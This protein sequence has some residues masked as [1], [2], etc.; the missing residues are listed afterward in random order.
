MINKY[1]IISL[2]SLLFINAI[3]N[4]YSHVNQL[5][6]ECK[7]SDYLQVKFCNSYIEPCFVNCSS[8]FSRALDGRERS[9]IIFFISYQN[10]MLCPSSEPSHPDGSEKGHLNHL[11]MVQMRGQVQMR[12]HNIA[13]YA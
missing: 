11:K 8:F 4:A 5:N 1:L 9:M 12:G 2:F 13:F 3:L 6:I 7:F 10:H